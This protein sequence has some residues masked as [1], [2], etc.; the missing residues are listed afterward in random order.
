ML[1]RT[2]FLLLSIFFFTSQN[3][4]FSQKK[5]ENDILFTVG[6]EEISAEEFKYVYS[7]NNSNND[8]A[9]TKKD[10]EQY[11]QLFINFKLKIAEAKSRKMDEDESFKNELAGYITQLKKPYLTENEVTNKLVKQAY[12]RYK[13]E[14]RASHILFSITNGDTLAAYKKAID[15]KSQIE[16][17]LK[18]SE[19]ALKYSDDPSAKVNNGDL[20]YFSSFQ[21]VYPFESGAYETEVGEVSVPI[22]TQFGYHL[23]YVKDKRAANGKVQVAHIMLRHK[24]DSL[25]IR[26][27][28]F[29]IHEQAK[30]GVDWNELVKQYS[31]DINS[32]NTNGVLRE[33]GVG[34]MPLE[35]QEAS[36]ELTEE[37]EI[38]DPIKTKYGWHIIKLINRTG[39]DSFENM[40]SFITQRISKDSRSQLNE[41][42]L[43]KRLKAENGF[44]ENKKSIDYLIGL[45]DTTLTA[46]NWQADVSKKSK[47]ELF[48][49]A[50][51]SFTIGEFVDY[52]KSL[53]KPNNVSPKI[54]LRQQLEDFENKKIKKYEEDHLEDK[55]ID[56]K[57][58]VKEYREGILL[59]ELMEKEV[60]NK[61]VEDTVGLQIFYE[62]NKVKYKWGERAKC[63]LFSSADK[64]IIKR[65]ERAIKESDS[66][67]LSKENLYK[68]YNSGSSI[69]L[70]LENG[71]FEHGRIEVLDLVKWENGIQLKTYAGKQ[72]LI[73]IKEIEPERIKLLNEAKGE[74]IS[75]YQEKLEKIWLKK[76]KEKYTVNVNSA[77]LNN[78]YEQ[79]VK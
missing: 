35:F 59:F 29:E 79:L 28:I 34:Q 68:T 20:G 60:W 26:D 15:V 21:M 9:F 18:F 71:L 58:L 3:S 41:K 70:D 4:S 63:R 73:W 16:K 43:I 51:N 65:I 39:L 19:A 17:G 22:K 62:N 1:R 46:G 6:D 32:K 37:G 49:V 42:V 75:D 12:D 69:Q 52:I 57:M 50:D 74:A 27:K 31:E 10:I 40:E 45:A 44:S 38:S 66:V 53:P 5:K 72:H 55:Y 76:L 54:Y 30:G 77:V 33:F 23:I 14:V 8:S 25:A 78:V 64:S 2:S 61:A 13:Q 56:Y 24:E 67:F 7:K 48:K 47:N 11:F 36:F